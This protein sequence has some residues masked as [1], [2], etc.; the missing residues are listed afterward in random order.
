MDI[1]GSR[2]LGC[3]RPSSVRF[4]LRATGIM[5]TACTFGTRAIGDRWLVT[6]E[7][8]ITDTGTQVSGT[9]VA[10]G[11]AEGSITTER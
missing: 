3:R 1:T 7:T 6:T 10:T 11:T 2:V 8:L 9:K 5:T 4:G